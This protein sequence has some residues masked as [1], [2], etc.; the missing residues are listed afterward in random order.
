MASTDPYA[1]TIVAP[2]SAENAPAKD[3]QIPYPATTWV[4][5]QSEV[6]LAWHPDLS[7]EVVIKLSRSQSLSSADSKRR[8]EVEAVALANLDHPHL[9]RVYDRDC[10][11]IGP[12][13]SWILYAAERWTSGCETKA[14]RPTKSRFCS[15][16]SR[17]VWRQ[18]IVKA[19]SPGYQTGQYPGRRQ[20][21]PRLIDFGLARRNDMW[22]GEA[23]TDLGIVGTMQVMSPEQAS[24]R[25]GQLSSHAD[26]FSLG[27]SCISL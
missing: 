3:W 1:D 19:S 9:I 17:A 6:F 2:V 16:N 11:R 20:G 25:L 7:K 26:V 24:G 8:F 4:W 21:E 23:G 14:P 27:A 5:C 22:D 12:T 13:W 15:T 10:S 18:R